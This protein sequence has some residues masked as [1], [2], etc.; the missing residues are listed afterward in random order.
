MPSEEQ[1]VESVRD[2]FDAWA[3]KGRDE[4]MEE[5]HGFAAREA[6]RRLG[7]APG[8]HYL[9]VGCGNGYSVRWAADVDPSVSA[10]GLDVSPEMIAKARA[11]TPQPNA[12][13]IH[14]PFPLP[15]LKA[16]TFH[17]IFSMEVFYY[18]PDLT[19]GILSAARLLVPGGLFA[20]VVDYYEENAASHGWPEDVGVAMH[21]LSEAGWRAAMEEVGLEVVEQARLR[22]PLAEGEAPSWKQTEGSLL[23]LARRPG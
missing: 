23:T 10:V 17:A 16:K 22:P 13:F 8:Q 14:A 20:C 3:R 4:G 7:V 19:W 5:G 21:R 9:D 2:L 12:R 1:Q 18:L 15:L 11:K 6:F